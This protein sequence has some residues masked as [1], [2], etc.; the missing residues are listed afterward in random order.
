MKWATTISTV[1]KYFNKY[2]FCHF[3][4]FVD[5]KTVKHIAAF[6]K[7]E[8]INHL[9]FCRLAPESYTISIRR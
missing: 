9:A 7:T 5:A 8:K 2:F 6:T 3:I 4:I 1:P